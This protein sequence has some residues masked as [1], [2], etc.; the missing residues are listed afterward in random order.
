LAKDFTLTQTA[1]FPF[2]H[3][4]RYSGRDMFFQSQNSG[5]SFL[6]GA[7]V[8]RVCASVQ[9]GLKMLALCCGCVYKCVENAH[10][11]AVLCRSAPNTEQSLSFMVAFFKLVTSSGGSAK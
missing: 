6:S 5:P 8:E 4:A 2:T 1:E 7:T 3:C 10:C 9:R 11:T